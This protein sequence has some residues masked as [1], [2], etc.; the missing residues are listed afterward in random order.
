[1]EA[2]TAKANRQQASQSRIVIHEE[3]GRRIAITDHAVERHQQ[4]LRPSMPISCAEHELGRLVCQAHIRAEPPVWVA[5]RI[6]ADRYPLLGADVALPLIRQG[7]ILIATT[8]I[9]RHGV[10]GQGS[11]RRAAKK[12]R[13]HGRHS[14]PAQFC[15]DP[16]ER[17]EPRPRASC[18]KPNRRREAI[19]P[20]TD[21]GR[22]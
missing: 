5:P 8:L 17:R 4:R 9:V 6:R 21:G 15:P 11:S 1:V 12:R 22:S 13:L 16:R 14:E 3:S 19:L 18:R 2:T 7:R 20:L 10:R